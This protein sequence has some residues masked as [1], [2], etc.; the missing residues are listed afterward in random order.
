MGKI[1]LALIMLT[2]LGM[3][4]ARAEDAPRLD[5]SDKTG[6]LVVGDRPFLMLGGEL[7]NSSASSLE[8]LD[9]LWPTLD[10]LHLNTVL[11]PVSWE[12]IEPEEGRFDFTLVDG[13]LKRA[14]THG[15]RLV[16]LWFGSRKN[17]MSSYAPAWV[18]RDSARF[19]RAEDA[20]GHKMESLSAFSK[21]NLAADRAA[22]VALMRHLAK[23]DAKT[24]T[25]IMAQV[26][27]EIGMIGA[28]RDHSPLANKAYSGDVPAALIRL[29]RESADK[30]SALK[31]A[32]IA[33]G[34]K[35]GGDWKT[36]FGA[37][38]R[39]EEIFQAWAFAGYAESVAAAGKAAYALPFY[40]NAALIRPGKKPG[41]YPSA[42]PLPHLLD[43]WRAAAPSIDLFAPDIYFPNF[44]DWAG[45][46]ASPENPLFIPEAGHAGAATA[47]ANAFFAFGELRAIGFSPFAINTMATPAESALADAYKALAGIASLIL[48]HEG[49]DQMRGFRAPVSFDG[50]PDLSPQTVTLGDCRITAQFIDP[51]TERD[52]QTPANHGALVIKLAENEFLF[53]GAGV[54]FTFE[55]ADGA[56]RAGVL[57]ADQVDYENGAERTLRRLNGDETHQG[58][59]IR[60]PPGAV[61]MQRVKLYRY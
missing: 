55:P 1:L 29:A 40:M 3:G 52:R 33:H 10:A 2:A 26:E 21:T 12:L 37:D 18:K 58:R 11:A 23:V 17:G 20:D 43:L 4:A 22:F 57:S 38:A 41:D 16:L 56:G 5:R 49:S 36:V 45:R 42:A 50:E 53:A 35:K 7:G 8:D 14:R 6:A 31:A 28:A 59:H 13:L 54:T 44:S 47:P 32:W 34:E 30:S 19:P 15:Q 48:A 51:W 9:A 25:V 24:R 60:L 61:T 39:G 27:N 46:Y